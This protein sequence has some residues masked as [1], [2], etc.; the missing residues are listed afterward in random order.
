MPTLHDDPAPVASFAPLPKL[1][2]GADVVFRRLFEDEAL[3]ISLLNAVLKLPEGKRIVSLTLLPTHVLGPLADDKEVILDVR[4]V[5]QD[6]TQFEVEVQVRAFDSY[7]ERLL[8]YWAGLYHGQLIAGKSY[9]DLRPV[10]GVHF[11]FFNLLP[12]EDRFRHFHHVFDVRERSTSYRLTDQLELHTLEML[13]FKKDLSGLADEE[14]KWLLFLKRGHQM[15]TDEIQG[16]GVPAI[17]E[18]EKKLNMISQDKILQMQYEQRRC[19]ELDAFA[20]AEDKWK[21]GLIEGKREGKA[22]GTAKA[23]LS[24]LQ[25]RG[26]PLSSVE[27]SAILACQDQATLDRWVPRALLASSAAELLAEG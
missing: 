7:A 2:P 19:A 22:E 27:Q 14:E 9:R 10:I 3:L 21:G 4:A 8:Y 15:T 16:L 17:V 25:A 23:I 6:G 24:I 20:Y 12:A 5:A 13:K 18:A 1:P 26:I 11:L